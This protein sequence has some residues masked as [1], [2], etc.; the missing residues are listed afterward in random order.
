MTNQDEIE[1]EPL[2][3]KD[4][5]SLIGLVIIELVIFFIATWRRGIIKAAKWLITFLKGGG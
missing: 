5:L 4:W 3:W 2:T 1:L